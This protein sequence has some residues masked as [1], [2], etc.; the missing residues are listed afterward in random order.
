MSHADGGVTC[1]DFQ[2]SMQVTPPPAWIFTI[3]IEVTLWALCKQ[4]DIPELLHWH[5]EIWQLRRGNYGRPGNTEFLG[6]HRQAVQPD[7]KIRGIVRSP[8][9]ECI[10]HLQSRNSEHSDQ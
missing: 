7:R 1:M 8:D 2:I 5:W 6:I 9:F 4:L 10:Q 3:P